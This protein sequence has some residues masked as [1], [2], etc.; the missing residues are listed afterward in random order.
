MKELRVAII[1]CGAI[2]HRHMKVWK[3]IPQVTVVAA[4]EID[5]PKLKAWGE[6]YGFEE[7]N[8]YHDFREMLKRDDIDAV[9]VC[10]HNNLHTPSP[11][12]S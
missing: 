11:P 10:V 12:T 6:R 9:D 3:N 8:L 4:A 7:K 2:S 5:A 1:G